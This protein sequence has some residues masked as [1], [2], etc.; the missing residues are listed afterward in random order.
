MMYFAKTLTR[1]QIQM[2]CELGESISDDIFP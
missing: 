2:G 1:E